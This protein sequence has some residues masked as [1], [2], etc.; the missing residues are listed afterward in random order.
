MAQKK[1]LK[2]ETGDIIEIL[3]DA[4][5][6]SVTQLFSESCR[7]IYYMEEKGYLISENIPY[8]C[9]KKI[10]YYDVL[11]IDADGNYVLDD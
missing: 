1:K 6:I 2:I 5:Q 9:I 7:G 11:K 10:N 3:E 4:P 8:P